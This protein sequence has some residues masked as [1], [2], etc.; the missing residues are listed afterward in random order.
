MKPEQA[1]TRIEELRSALRKHNHNYYVKSRPSISDFEYDLLINELQSLEKQF[2]QFD[3]ENSPSRRVGSDLNREFTSFPHRYPMLSLGNTYSRDE[4]AE[5]DQRVRKTL[6][7]H[8]DYFCELKYDGVAVSLTYRNGELFRALT[9]GDGTRGDDVT[10]NIRTIRSIPLNLAADSYPA[11]FEIRGEVILPKEGFREMNAERLKNN[12]DPFA[13]PRNAA[14][15]TLKMQNSALVARRP[16]DCLFYYIPGEQLLF[17]TQSESLE[18]AREWGFKVPEQNRLAG[19]LDQVFE[20]I[21]HWEAERDSL[22]FEIDGVVVKVDAIAMQQQLGFTA[23]TPRWAISYKFRA[24]QA[25]TRLLSVDFQVGRT[26]AVTPV[27]NLEPVLLAGTTVKRASLH[28]ADQIRLLDI[29]VG[30]YVYVEKG[31]EII[32]KIVGVDQGRRETGSEL[33]RFISQCPECGSPLVR[34]EDEAAHYCPNAAGCPPQIKGRIEHF[35]SRKA[36]DINAAEATI[37]LLYR[38]GLV[39]DVADLYSLETGQVHQLER[40]GEKSA[41]N[42]IESIDR[43]RQV[44]FHRVLYALGIRYVGETVARTLAE[45]FLSLDRLMEATQEELEEVNE[46]G[47]R[48]A[49]SL[50]SYFQEEGN[51]R[52]LERLK[53]AGLQ[54]EMEQPGELTSNS[55]AGQTFVISG[56]FARHSREELKAIIEQHGGKNSASISARTHFVIAGENMG[57]SKYEKAQKLGIPIISEEDFMEMLSQ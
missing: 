4:L 25:L 47:E 36:M 5:F 50:L 18:K 29:R 26:G 57:P 14:S 34:R 8:V 9:R 2:P 20:F 45:A 46:I 1:L 23:K 44:P 3:N 56:V 37:D 52:L 53:A 42:L 51:L 24:E 11:E 16:L 33:F 15:G 12:E 17:Q 31:G 49:Q 43:S 38:K 55:L 32:P 30:D 7:D 19:S 41:R 10:H 22:P 40:F 48:I 28:N 21:E 6:G 13:N 35:I 54:F 27:A 39:R